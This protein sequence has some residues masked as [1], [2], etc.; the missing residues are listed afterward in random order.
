MELHNK[1]PGG[2]CVPSPPHQDNWYFNKVDGEVPTIWVALEQIDEANG[3]LRYVP[4]THALPLRTH[5]KSDFFGFSQTVRGRG[6]EHTEH[7]C[8]TA[9]CVRRPAL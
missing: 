9:H 4:G 6:A 1:G 5:R 8:T 2:R 7:D 3:C